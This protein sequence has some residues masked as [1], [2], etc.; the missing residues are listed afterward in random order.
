MLLS[1]FVVMFVYP[2]FFLVA[3][4]VTAIFLHV[5]RHRMQQ[6]Y[7]TV[8]E[9]HFWEG[10]Q[11]TVA[12]F[13]DAHGTYWHGENLFSCLVVYHKFLSFIIPCQYNRLLKNASKSACCAANFSSVKVTR[14]S[15][16]W[17]LAGSLLVTGSEQSDK[18]F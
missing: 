1:P 5:Y 16:D 6:I 12:A 3:M 4:Y 13:F 8:A 15:C 17:Y 14:Q 11:Q 2:A 18:N 10:A 9:L 7:S